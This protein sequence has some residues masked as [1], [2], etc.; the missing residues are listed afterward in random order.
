MTKEL[1]KGKRH[2]RSGEGVPEGFALG[3]RVRLRLF[4]CEREPFLAKKA[5]CGSGET[6]LYAA[7][8]GKDQQIFTNYMRCEIVGIRRSL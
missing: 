1:W 2:A 5:S 3:S 6:V 7:D 8:A 4:L